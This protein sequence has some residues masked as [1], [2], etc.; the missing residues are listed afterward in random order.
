MNKPNPESKTK[1]VILQALTIEESQMVTAFKRLCRQDGLTEKAMLLEALDLLFVKHRVKI[2]GN[3][4][5]QL[6]SPELTGVPMVYCRCGKPAVKEGVNQKNGKKISVCLKC[7]S[8]IPMRY[9]RRVWV[10]STIK[11][12]GSK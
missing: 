7:F 10:F 1:R 4:Q 8:A 9:D 12:E 2:G 6:D 3:S 5:L 11:L